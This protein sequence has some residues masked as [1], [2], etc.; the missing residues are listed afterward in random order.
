VYRA[1]KIVSEPGNAW[2]QTGQSFQDERDNREFTTEAGVRHKPA[3]QVY[4]L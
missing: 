1:R 4:Q 3:A 2:R